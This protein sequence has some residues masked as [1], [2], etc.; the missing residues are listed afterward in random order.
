MASPAAGS[1]DPAVGD[2]QGDCCIFAGEVEDLCWAHMHR[3]DHVLNDSKHAGAC[4]V[5]LHDSMK[6][7]QVALH[8][9]VPL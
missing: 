2:T 9:S 8:I 3:V 5:W 7:S 1:F 4:S 6:G